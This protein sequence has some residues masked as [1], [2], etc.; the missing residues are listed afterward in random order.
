MCKCRLIA[1]H[2]PL[3][4]ISSFNSGYSLQGIL[5]ACSICVQAVETNLKCLQRQSRNCV[6][7]VIEQSKKWGRQQVFAHASAVSAL[8][9]T[10]KTT[11]EFLESEFLL[12][13]A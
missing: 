5:K 4:A 6:N 13:L 9:P 2:K 12:S 11:E 7:N 10:N 8:S 3:K 1:L